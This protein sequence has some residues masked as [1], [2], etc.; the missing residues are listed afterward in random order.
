MR[1]NYLIKENSDED[2]PTETQ[3]YYGKDFSLF[4]KNYIIEGRFDEILIFYY[5]T[6]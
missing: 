1:V 3:H 5:F 6:I 2:L 4:F